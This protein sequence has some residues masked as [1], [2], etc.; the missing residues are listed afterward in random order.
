VRNL[1]RT[2][3]HRPTSCLDYRLH[4]RKAHAA[5]LTVCHLLIIMN[6]PGDRGHMAKTHNHTIS[7]TYNHWPI[8]SI[9]SRGSSPLTLRRLVRAQRDAGTMF[10]HILPPL[11]RQ[12]H[13][14][15]TSRPIQRPRQ[16]PPRLTPQQRHSH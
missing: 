11:P 13:R 7:T 9:M 1:P 16:H 10:Q 3:L 4:S 12:S 2:A 15:H 8:N 6:T 14:M 5:Q